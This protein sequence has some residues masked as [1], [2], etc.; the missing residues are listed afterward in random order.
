MNKNLFDNV[1]ID[2]AKTFVPNGKAEDLVAEGIKY[3]K[4]I[5][6]L[7]GI[8]LQLLGIGVDGHI[9]F[10]EPD[11]VFTAPTHPVD[12][13][14]STIEANSRFFTSADEVP[15]MAITMGMASIMKA[16]KILLVANGKAKKEVVHRAINGPVDPMLPASILQLHPDVTIIFSEE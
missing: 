2:K 10:N 11:S 15:K 8:D 12:L 1:N 5:E 4:M 16:K 9:G 6:D 3:D 7:G 13:H 14:P